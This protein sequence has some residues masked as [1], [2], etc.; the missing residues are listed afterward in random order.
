MSKKEIKD[1]ITSIR[2][3]PTQY[4]RVVK[5]AQHRQWSISKM[6]QFIIDSVCEYYFVEDSLDFR[7]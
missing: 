4:A 1:K 7:R 3:T 2:L 5:L 6:I